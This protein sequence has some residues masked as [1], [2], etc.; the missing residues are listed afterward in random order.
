M[1]NKLPI[2]LFIRVY[3]YNEYIVDAKTLNSDILIYFNSL[4]FFLF[5]A[6][7][8][9]LYDPFLYNNIIHHHQTWCVLF[10]RIVLCSFC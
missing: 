2:Y 8:R 5:F 10:V 3:L 9:E 7:L 6:V 1:P 4:L